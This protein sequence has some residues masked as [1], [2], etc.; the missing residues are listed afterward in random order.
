MK[1]NLIITLIVGL[2]IGFAVGKM[3]GTVKRGPDA[4]AVP[5]AP[6]G[7]GA[8]G[9][10]DATIIAVP[11]DGSPTRGPADALVTIV[12]FSDYQ[13]PFCSRAHDVVTELERTYGNKVRVVMK[14]RPLTAIHPRATPAALAALAAGKQGKYWEMHDKLFANQARLEDADLESY[15]KELGLNVDNWRKALTDA[16]VTGKVA[17]DEAL[18]N[19]IGVGGTP[20]FFINGKQLIGALPAAEFK[21]VIDAE[22][23]KAQDL[24]ANGT[25]A[26]EVYAKIMSTGTAAPA[27]APQAAPSEPAQ[28]PAGRRKIAIPASAPI[29]GPKYA[30]VTIVEW[31]DFECPFCARVNPT[32]EQIMKEYKGSVRLVF[33]HQPLPFHSNAKIAAQASVAAQEQGKFWEMHDRLFADQK[34]ISRD[35]IMEHAKAL[36]LDMKR[37]TAALDAPATVKRVESDSSEGMQVGANG[38]PTFYVNG[39]EVVGAQPFS[40]FKRVIDAELTRA[41]AALKRGVKMENL[42]EELQKD[43]QAAAPQPSGGGGG[44]P[45][46]AARVVTDMNIKGAPS[47]GP[48]NAPVTIVAFSDYQCPFCTRAEGTLKDL[49]KKYPSKL[50]FVFKHMPMPFHAQAKGAA[51]A[52]MAANE[53]GKFWAMHDKLFS[54]QN[55]LDRSTFESYAKELNLDTTKFKAALDSNK[56]AAYVEADI[57]EGTRLGVNGTPTFFINGREL[58]GAQPIESFQQV[59]DAELA[60]KK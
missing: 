37:F 20:T 52:S 35:D 40:E 31:S 10:G 25:P 1:P 51:A 24:V 12:E 44:A 47:K 11:V 50:R 49:E 27:P 36:K 41:D 45:A 8:G 38:T 23:K 18:A 22:L 32:V 5:S 43:A 56:Y 16:S 60:K 54:N 57:A 17:E 19:K 53:Q 46:P 55:N 2:G 14:Q 42:Y 21:T 33:R 58:V 29:R 15:A 34:K 3:S 13:C 26:K 6:S 59:I 9:G 39:Q 4:A 30:K 48:A 7:G 28:A